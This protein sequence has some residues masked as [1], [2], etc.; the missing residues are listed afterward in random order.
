MIL[1]VSNIILRT[2]FS[3]PIL[4]AYEYA[5]LLT[6][7]VIALGV[8]NC[9]VN[10]AHIAV[11]FIIERLPGK[12]KSFFDSFIN[13][14]AVLF[15]GVTAWHVGKYAQS[16][17]AK[18]VVSST[19]QVPLYPFIYV[20]ALGLFVLCLVLMVKLIESIKKVTT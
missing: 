2:V 15:W 14:T 18:N 3:H 5:G 13:F 7:I 17:A 4:G 12:T 10:N 9:A 8:A 19:A 11:D 20:I 6:S 1:V 16:T